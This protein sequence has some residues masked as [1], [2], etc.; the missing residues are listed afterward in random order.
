M[1][2]FYRKPL[3]CYLKKRLNDGDVKAADG[4]TLLRHNV[5]P[6]EIGGFQRRRTVVCVDPVWSAWKNSD[7]AVDACPHVFLCSPCPRTLSPC[8]AA[9]PLQPSRFSLEAAPSH[10]LCIGPSPAL[11]FLWRARWQV[12]F[13]GLQQLDPLQLSS[14][15]LKPCLSLFIIFCCIDQVFQVISK[16]S[17]QDVYIWAITDINPFSY[18]FGES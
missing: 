9:F 3:S 4:C 7:C 18:I 6:V 1:Y 16:S 11:T 13:R 14:S 8:T 12:P 2:L 10:C 15:Q 17:V 5:V